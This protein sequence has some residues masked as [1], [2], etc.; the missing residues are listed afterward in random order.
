MDIYQASTDL[1][2]PILGCGWIDKQYRQTIQEM[3]FIAHH[4][5]PRDKKKDEVSEVML[6]RMCLLLCLTSLAQPKITITHGASMIYAY[7]FAVRYAKI[8]GLISYLIVYK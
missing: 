2:P 1:Y 7:F 4:L 8:L 3:I 6:L 5:T